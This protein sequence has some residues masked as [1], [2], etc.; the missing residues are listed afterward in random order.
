MT[1][2]NASLPTTRLARI[3]AT[4]ATLGAVAVLAAAPAWAH[5]HVDAD[6]AAPGEHAIVT[7]TVPN[8]SEKGSATTEFKVSL[9]DLTSVSTRQTPG[10]SA[11]LDR[12]VAAG[13]VTSI[14]WTAAPGAGILP[15]EFA[16]F[17]VSVMLPNADSVSF[18]A[19]QTY[20]DGEVVRWDEPAPAGGA[21]PEHPAPTLALAATTEPAPAEPAAMD[22]HRSSESDN[23]ARWLGGAGLAVAVLAAIVAVGRRRT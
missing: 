17:G 3:G 19:T 9:P 8:E 1:S 2:T 15:D 12:D 22:E 21:E 11:R 4:I 14:T 20:S 7:F 23:T 5:V 13:T 6:A 10:W 16:L 18:P